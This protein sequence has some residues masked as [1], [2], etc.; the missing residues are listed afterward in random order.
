MQELGSFGSPNFCT[1]GV[2][3]E[4]QWHGFRCL[5][6]REMKC[7]CTLN[8][9]EMKWNGNE[10]LFIIIIIKIEKI[11]AFFSFM[12]IDVVF[13]LFSFYVW[14]N[15]NKKKSIGMCGA[16][17]WASISPL[18]KP[19]HQNQ[20][21]GFDGLGSCSI[22]IWIDVLWIYYFFFTLFLFNYFIFILW[23]LFYFASTIILLKFS[24][25]KQRHARDKRSERGVE[26]ESLSSWNI[27]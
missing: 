12:G 14:E 22:G 9:L 19:Y 15:K 6:R 20:R 2:L 25:G 18:I 10:I 21:L 8:F 26:W 11:G 23:G 24:D 1:L 7:S 16:N 13:Y 17:E 4:L 5:N 3:F 27:Y